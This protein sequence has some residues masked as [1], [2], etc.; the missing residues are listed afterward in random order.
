MRP[1]FTQHELLQVFDVV[2]VVDDGVG[3]ENRAIGH[4]TT[5]FVIFTDCNTLL[6]TEAVRLL[7]RHYQD[8]QVGAVSGEKRVLRDGSTSG[9]S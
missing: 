8:P 9:A 5:P 4:V 6:N 3:A 1:I 7:V 2:V